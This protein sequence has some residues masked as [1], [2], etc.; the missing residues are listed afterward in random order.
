MS[1]KWLCPPTKE[2]GMAGS[3][4]LKTLT[5]TAIVALAAVIAAGC[6]GGGGSGNSTAATVPPKTANGQVATLG[7]ATTGLG[8]VLVNSQARTLYLFKADQGTKSACVGACAQAW[9]PL[10]AAGTPALGT[11]LQSSAVRTVKRSDGKPQVAYH[12]HPLYTYTGDQKAGDTTG[13]GLT[14]FGG[15]WFA[16]TS[17]GG[18][19][20]GSASGPAGPNGY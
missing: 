7:V 15:A 17:S 16:L 2:N 9:P 13:Q 3:R 5:G 20:S 18:Q 6:G 8:K 19:A 11:G 12:G 4:P 1:G 14:A 10:R